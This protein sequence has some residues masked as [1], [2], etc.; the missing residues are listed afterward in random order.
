MIAC[1]LSI[2][3]RGRTSS[4]ATML[5]YPVEIKNLYSRSFGIK[6]KPRYIFRAESLD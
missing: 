4:Y 1:G 5:R 3:P 6:L 2:R